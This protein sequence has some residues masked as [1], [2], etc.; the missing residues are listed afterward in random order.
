MEK[1]IQTINFNI[2]FILS[3]YSQIRSHNFDTGW[4]LC[5]ISMVLF[6]I[7]IKPQ[8]DTPT[9]VTPST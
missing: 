5:H 6:P 9:M 8:K 4:V 7:L 2:R 1:N 3:S